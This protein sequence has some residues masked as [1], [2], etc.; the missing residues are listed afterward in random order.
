VMPILITDLPGKKE[1]WN[2]NLPLIQGHN[3]ERVQLGMEN[4]KCIGNIYLPKKDL[5]NPQKSNNEVF[6]KHIWP[7]RDK[8]PGMVIH[9]CNPSYSGGRDQEG[10]G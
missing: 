6:W 2:V 1:A 9:A 3:S 7:K 5:K 4:K 10:Y 8:V